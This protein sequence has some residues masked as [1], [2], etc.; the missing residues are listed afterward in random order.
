M[1][2]SDGLGK[3]ASPDLR[4]GRYVVRIIKD[5]FEPQEETVDLPETAD[6]QII[7]AIARQ[8]IGISV[9]GNAL[10]FAS[11]DPLYRQ[12]REIGLGQTFRVDN[13]ALT[14]EAATFQFRKGTLFYCAQWMEL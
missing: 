2:F 9:P 8:K 6:L 7:L 5:G 13:F 12:L 4:T 10:A 11:S 3:F 14:W 1:V